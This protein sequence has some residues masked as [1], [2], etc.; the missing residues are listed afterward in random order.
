MYPPLSNGSFDEEE[1]GEEDDPKFEGAKRRRLTSAQMWALKGGCTG[2]EALGLMKATHDERTVAE[3]EKARRRSDRDTAAAKLDEE[4]K[5]AAL[6]I[7]VTTVLR[8]YRRTVLWLTT[9]STC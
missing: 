7:D 3:V 5:R 4:A 8:Q 9:S 2:E 6:P 1:N